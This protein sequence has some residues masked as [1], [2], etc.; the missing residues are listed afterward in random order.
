MNHNGHTHN[1][2]CPNCGEKLPYAKAKMNLEK[3]VRVW[4]RTCTACGL[5]VSDTAIYTRETF[6]PEHA[7][8]PILKH[9]GEGGM[10][11]G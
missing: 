4:K 11:A 2:Q 5:V 9:P 1:I 7:P 6:M 8:L 3:S 10:T